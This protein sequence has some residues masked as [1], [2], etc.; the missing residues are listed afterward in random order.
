MNE[1]CKVEP[2]TAQCWGCM[3]EEKDKTKR[4]ICLLSSDDGEDSAMFKRAL[5]GKCTDYEPVNQMRQMSREI[6]QDELNATR[7]EIARE[8]YPE[9][10]T[11]EAK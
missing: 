9:L 11:D 5:N 1:Q 7:E 2:L 3:R 8:C 10:F 6:T 4:W